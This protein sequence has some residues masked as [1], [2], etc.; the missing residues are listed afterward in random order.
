MT[1][2]CFVKLFFF[3]FG[4]FDIRRNYL[5]NDSFMLQFDELMILRNIVFNCN[6]PGIINCFVK[7][8]FFLNLDCLYM[9]RSHS[10]SETYQRV[11]LKHYLKSWSSIG[12]VLKYSLIVTLQ[13]NIV[14]IY[15][16]TFLIFYLSIFIG[17]FCKLLFLDYFVYV[18]RLM[19][20]IFNYF[21]SLN[22]LKC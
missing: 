17:F 8:F 10:I 6:V 14:Y 2:D 21:T 20:D 16:W 12:I 9:H 15:F 5:K 7:L 4:L 19:S 3:L 11:I 18:C 1:F 13:I 22:Y